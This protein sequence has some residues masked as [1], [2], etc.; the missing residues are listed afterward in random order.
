MKYI[1]R[2]DLMFQRDHPFCDSVSDKEAFR[3]MKEAEEIENTQQGPAGANKAA[4]LFRQAFRMS[5]TLAKVY[6]S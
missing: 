6:G 4:D 1:I 3:L 5:P 2:T